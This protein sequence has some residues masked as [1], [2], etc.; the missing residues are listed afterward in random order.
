MATAEG[1]G[2]QGNA[3]PAAAVRYPRQWNMRAVQADVAWAHGFLGSSSVSIFMLDSG[4][5]PHHADTERRAD[6]TPSLELPG[7]CDGPAVVDRDT[8]SVAFRAPE[9]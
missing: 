1:G 3:A 5:D 9:P 7:P 2:V 8:L 6:A 4:I